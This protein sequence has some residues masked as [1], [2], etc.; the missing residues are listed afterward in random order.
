[1]SVKKQDIVTALKQIGVKRGDILLVH[2]SLKSFGM[3]VE[4]G[5]ETVISA[6]K[7]TLT[8]EGTL[9]MPTFS[10]KNFQTVYKDWSLERPSDTGYITEVFRLQAGTLRSDQ[11]TH[12]VAA[13]GRYAKEITEGHTA[14]GPRYGAYGDYA[15]SHSSPWQKMYDMRAKVLFMG[16]DPI[17]ANTFRHF[18]EYRLVEELLNK[19][20]SSPYYEAQK[21]KLRH[22]EGVVQVKNPWP[23]IINMEEIMKGKGIF[24]YRRCA[25]SKFALADVRKMVDEIEKAIRKQPKRY[26]MDQEWLEESARVC[27]VDFFPERED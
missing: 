12:S 2:S 10:Q 27:R 1:M 20:N 9:V 7:E 26:L 6:L 23:Y 15:F 18:C 3:D 21:K 17:E 14:F 8:Q 16:A 4:G 19:I 22:F 13:S 5:A 25:Q 11:A 24:V